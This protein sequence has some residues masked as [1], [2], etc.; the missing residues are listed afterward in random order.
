MDVSPVQRCMSDSTMA[1]AGRKR[2]LLVQMFK[3]ASFGICV[4][5]LLAL[6]A[7]LFENWRGARAWKAFRAE[8]ESK[9]ERF[10]LAAFKPAPVPD[11]Q[12]FALTPLLAPMLDYQRRPGRPVQ[13][14]DPVGKD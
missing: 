4:L 10:D 3:F 1:P 7:W 11:E 2:S 13:W 5:L 9:G 12:N 8:W 6:A 14:R